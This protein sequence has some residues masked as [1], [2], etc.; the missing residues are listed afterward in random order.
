ML[1]FGPVLSDPSTIMVSMREI[2]YR[3]PARDLRPGMVLRNLGTIESIGPV[4]KRRRGHYYPVRMVGGAR[5]YINIAGT[6][7]VVSDN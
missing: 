7:V 6:V 1:R 3:T 2:E 4:Q 5:E